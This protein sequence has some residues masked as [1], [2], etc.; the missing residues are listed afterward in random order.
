M[1]VLVRICPTDVGANYFVMVIFMVLLRDSDRWFVCCNYVEAL[2]SAVVGVWLKQEAI[3]QK[4]VI[5][6]IEQIR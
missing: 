5:G 4:A 1:T 6:T 2:I 3:Q